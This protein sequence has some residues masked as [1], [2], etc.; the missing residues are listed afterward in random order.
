MMLMGYWDIACTQVISFAFGAPLFA[1]GN[2]QEALS[3]HG[4]HHNLHTIWK[5]GDGSPAFFTM[6]SDLASSGDPTSDTKPCLLPHI[7]TS[8]FKLAQVWAGALQSEL[9][10]LPRFSEQ[11]VH[12]SAQPVADEYLAKANQQR[13]QEGQ[14]VKPRPPSLEILRGPGSNSRKEGPV[15][16]SSHA[17]PSP[18]SSIGS[19]SAAP[20]QEV[21]VAAAGIPARMISRS[22]STG[23]SAG[24]VAVASV[25]RSTPTKPLP[26]NTVAVAQDGSTSLK[27]TAALRRA[28]VTASAPT[29]SGS[30]WKVALLKLLGQAALVTSGSCCSSKLQPVGQFWVLQCATDKAPS[31]KASALVM[32]KS[33]VA[34]PIE[35]LS[36]DSLHASTTS[37]S[38]LSEANKD[39]FNRWFITK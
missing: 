17:L 1:N 4:L 22:Y 33:A 15:L 35:M 26:S 10:K 32:T 3:S 6:C 21:Q 14:P 7:H 28:I 34:E 23:M 31:A 25:Q 16:D 2:L 39:L 13:Q 8:G 27:A 29:P 20:P 38:W 36:L 5:A 24:N 18:S 12:S 9:A 37:L 30:S 19:L 11:H